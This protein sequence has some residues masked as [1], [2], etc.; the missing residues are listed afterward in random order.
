MK[1]DIPINQQAF[2]LASA[3]KHAGHVVRQV[4]HAALALKLAVMK[5]DAVADPLAKL[6]LQALERFD[7]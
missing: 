6:L 1:P 3:S 5:D 7:A 2:F 4:R